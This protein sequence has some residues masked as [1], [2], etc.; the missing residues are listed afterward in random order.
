MHEPYGIQH[1]ITRRQ[2]ITGA[3]ATAAVLAL[4]NFG[5]GE[6]VDAAGVPSLAAIGGGATANMP[7]VRGN[8]WQETPLQ[9]PPQ[10]WRSGQFVLSVFTD[11][12]HYSGTIDDGP[13]PYNTDKVLFAADKNKQQLTFFVI[14]DMVRAFPEILQRTYNAGHQIGGHSEH[15]T[16]YTAVG[17]APQ[18]APTQEIIKSVIGVYPTAVRAPGLTRGQVYLD[19]AAAAGVYEVQTDWNTT[20]YLSPRIPVSEIYAQHVNGLKKGGIELNHDGGNARPTPDAYDSMLQYSAS[21]GITSVTIDELV[22]GG[23]PQPAS[24]GYPRL[25]SIQTLTAFEEPMLDIC[26]FDVYKELQ[27]FLKDGS[28]K[29]VQQSRVKAVLADID[30][31]RLAS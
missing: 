15:H 11:L 25:A 20:D 22:N 19:A 7:A 4:A 8:R 2:L 1:E 13:S 26:N 6:G 17:L 9:P 10:N 28:L 30:L 21:V 3:A 18:I 5:N 29:S 27:G 12:P 16:P 24:G 31:M 23:T 14:G